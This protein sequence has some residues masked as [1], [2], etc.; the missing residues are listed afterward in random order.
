VEQRRFDL[1]WL[2]GINPAETNRSNR[3][4][5][6]VYYLAVRDLLGAPDRAA[7]YAASA[8][9]MTPPTD[10]HPFFFHF[11][12][13]QQ[14]PE[15]LASLGHT[16]QPFGGSGYLVLLALLALAVLLGLVLILLPL[17]FNRAASRSA[18]PQG[19]WMLLY[20]A[21]LGFAFLFVEIPLIQRWI[22]LLG[23]P[24]YAF[25]AVVLVL[26]LCSGAGSALARHPLLPGWISWGFL[27]ALA[28]FLPWGVM[29]LSA[30]MLAWPAWARLAGAVFGL[31]PLG[32]LM[33][34]PFPRGLAWLES[35]APGWT[36]WAWA[37]NGCA[38]VSAAVLAA[39]LA[40]QS[41]FS[42]VLWLGAGAYGAAALIFWGVSRR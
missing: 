28:G 32:F 36:P 19:G 11:F 7:F 18:P 14:T 9:D 34:L 8:F 27:V 6:P 17:L 37:V 21:L 12:T 41:G 38:S 29:R 2:P 24:T 4:P 40:L 26:L 5:E 31:A 42:L 22:L 33:G 23:H 16:W 20:F 25:A 10:N 1:V 3:L 30:A 35:H 39:I 15:L 13:W